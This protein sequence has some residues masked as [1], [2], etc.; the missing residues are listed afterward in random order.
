MSTATA[1]PETYGLEGDD[2]LKTLR[3]TGLRQ[4][5]K[6]AFVRFRAADGFTNAR[7]LAWA[8]TLTI[9]PFVI[10]FVG[11][12]SLLDQD[13]VS[14]AVVKTVEEIAPGPAS[15]IFSQAF[16]QGTKSAKGGSRTALVLGT[17]AALAAGTTAMGQVERGANR[18]YGIERDRPTL[19]KY[20]HGFLLAMSS[21]VLIVL[22][23]A[24]LVAGSSVAEALG[25]DDA[26][27]VVWNLLRWPLG[28]ALAV[29][30][31]A[32]LFQKAP[33]RRQPDVTWLAFGSGLAVVLWLVFTA[34]L[35]VYLTASSSFGQTYGP[36]AGTIGVLLWAFL[37]SLALYLGIAFAAQLE[38][39]RA[40]S[41]TPS[42]GEAANPRGPRIRQAR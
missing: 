5:A 31:F 25:I 6:D 22:A 12:T 33:N 19:D 11:F 3:S 8:I 30:A 32:L 15:Q 10:A 1:V 23:M 18:I 39:V 7:S 38:A 36:L 24:L 13:R 41:P 26:L 17:A 35:A 21:G 16:R 2:A 29:G 28:I 4:L 27:G 9:L 20:R 40:G 34:A 42:T 14:R 37:T